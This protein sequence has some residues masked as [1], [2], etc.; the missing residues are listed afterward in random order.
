MKGIESK[1]VGIFLEDAGAGEDHRISGYV[2]ELA[3][4]LR[5][6]EISNGKRGGGSTRL[7]DGRISVQG[8]PA[9][10]DS[11]RVSLQALAKRQGVVLYYREAGA[12]KAPPES[13]EVI[14]AV[15]DKSASR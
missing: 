13:F 11:L 12:A 10:I 1:G 8:S 5:S 7:L 4:G 2:Q 14:Q 3:V 9:T 15:I 6:L